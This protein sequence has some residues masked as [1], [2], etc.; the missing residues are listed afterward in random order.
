M[1]RLSRA[2]PLVGILVLAGVAGVFAKQSDSRPPVTHIREFYTDYN[3]VCC[4]ST[5]AERARLA[6]YL[7]QDLLPEDI[8]SLR[9]NAVFRR[10]KRILERINVVDSRMA[11]TPGGPWTRLEFL[12]RADMYEVKEIRRTSQGA[13]VDVEILTLKPEEILRFIKRYDAAAEQDETLPEMAVKNPHTP[14][15]NA[16]FT[17]EVH[18]WH[19]R[20]GRWMKLDSH[21]TFLKEKK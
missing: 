16:V 18:V 17:K 11:I 15:Q 8:D 20:Q 13:A 2:G 1:K 12:F 14:N 5:K 21:F 19:P 9:H 6:G 10:M 7:E 4:L 3:F